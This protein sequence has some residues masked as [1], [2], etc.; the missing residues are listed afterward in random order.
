MGR[1][2]YLDNSSIED[3]LSYWIIFD[4]NTPSTQLQSGGNNDVR[5]RLRSKFKRCMAMP[6]ANG[7]AAIAY[8]KDTDSRYWP[9]GT[10]SP[11][12]G[13]GTMGN[14]LWYTFQNIITETNI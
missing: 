5:Q 8:L 6:Q 2:R 7:K 12:E 11:V 13:G 3:T 4:E 9:D 1:R 14:I 10:T